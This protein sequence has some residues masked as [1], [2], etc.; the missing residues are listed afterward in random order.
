M[1]DCEKNVNFNNI[2]KEEYN[3]QLK[4]FNNY[5]G[6]PFREEQGTE[7]ILNII[8]KYSKDGTLIDFGSGSNIYF[9]LIAFKNIEKILCVDISKEAF[10]INEKIRKKELYPKSCE[11]ALKKYSKNFDD[12]LKTNINYLVY[13]IFRF[14]IDMA[15]KYDNVTQFGLLGLCK[16]EREYTRNLKKIYCLVNNNGILIGAN[17]CFS[18]AYSNKMGF[19]NNYLSEQLIQSFAK[20]NDCKVLFSK[21]IPI[22]ND[23]NYKSVLVYVLK[24]E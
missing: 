18:S 23:E 21:M 22:K 14:P 10:F 13:D 19:N 11:Y 2:N 8:N 3:K 6:S 12:I 16:N 24:N 9:W 20:E 17:W 1:N 5:Y 4:Y 15:I 7:E